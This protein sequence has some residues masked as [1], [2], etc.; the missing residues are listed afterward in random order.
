VLEAVESLHPAIELPDSRFDDFTSVGA[1]QLI[2]DDACAH[3][4]VLGPATKADWRKLDLARHKVKAKVAGKASGSTL[5]L[6]GSGAAALGDP[7]VALTWLVNELSGL[8]ITLKAGQFVT[9]GT[10]VKPLP[11]APGDTVTA[12]MGKLGKATLK[13]TA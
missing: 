9:T 4:F 2:A 10:C 7:R 3:E 8:G 11:V 5:E 1:A 6:E 13:L 12:D